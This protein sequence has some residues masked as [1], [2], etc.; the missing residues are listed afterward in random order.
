MPP[1]AQGVNA[2]EAT[3]DPESVLEE[4]HHAIALFLNVFPPDTWFGSLTETG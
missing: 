4:Q 3:E 1:L 2:S